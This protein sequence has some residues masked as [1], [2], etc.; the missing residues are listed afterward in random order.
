[1]IHLNMG[2][3]LGLNLSNTHECIRFSLSGKKIRNSD[4]RAFRWHGTIQEVE[5]QR[6]TVDARVD[7]QSAPDAYVKLHVQLIR[8][9]GHYT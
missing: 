4:P 2:F 8:G 5:E 1:M 7:V 6:D 3:G 9:E